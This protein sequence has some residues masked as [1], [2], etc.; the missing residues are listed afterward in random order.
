MKVQAS[1]IAFITL[2]TSANG[3]APA[4]LITSTTKVALKGA[5]VEQFEL[6]SIEDAVSFPLYYCRHM[7]DIVPA[8]TG[9]HFPHRVFVV[10]PS[11]WFFV[12]LDQIQA[13]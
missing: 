4:T 5:M 8:A 6:G 2:A 11:W 12:L 3:F 1:A 9:R 7:L 10:V 13:W